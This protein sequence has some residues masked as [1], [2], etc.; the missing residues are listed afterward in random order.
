MLQWPESIWSARSRCRLLQDLNASQLNEL[1]RDL[2]SEIPS[3]CIRKMMREPRVMLKTQ[4]RWG[5]Q[6]L[7][8][9]GGK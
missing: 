1:V 6:G 4:S 8:D 7:S 9:G 3:T 2:H 5:P